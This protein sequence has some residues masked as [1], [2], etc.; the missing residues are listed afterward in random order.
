MMTMLNPIPPTS[1]EP[2]T[3][4]RLEVDQS[5]VES[6]HEG[7]TGQLDITQLEP[8]RKRQ[9]DGESDWPVTITRR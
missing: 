4:R 8:A 6:V 3:T 7:G 9:A 2:R 5:S 1:N